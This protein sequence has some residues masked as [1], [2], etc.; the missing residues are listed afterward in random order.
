MSGGVSIKFLKTRCGVFL[1][2]S[3]QAHLDFTINTENEG[4]AQAIPTPSLAEI[5]SSWD[6]M[7][8]KPMPRP[9]IQIF[10]PFC[11]VF[12]LVDK[13]PLINSVWIRNESMK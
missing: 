4:Q 1:Q 12:W 11:F 5:V 7:N 13:T 10:H 3:G 9:K 6:L 2:G 8:R